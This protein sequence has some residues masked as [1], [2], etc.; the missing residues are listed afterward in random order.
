MEAR[1]SLPRLGLGIL[2]R[3]IE[4]LPDELRDAA[5]RQPPRGVRLAA[6]RRIAADMAVGDDPDIGSPGCPPVE[7]E[8]FK[9]YRRL[10]AAIAVYRKS[11]VPG[12][13]DIDRLHEPWDGGR[14][15]EQIDIALPAIAAARG[16]RT[17][18]PDHRSAG[19]HV[20]GR[21]VESPAGGIG[22]SDRVEHLLVDRLHEQATQ[23]RGI[24]E[25]RTEQGLQAVGTKDIARLC[26]GIDA[27][28]K[29]VVVG[30]EERGR[31]LQR[32]GGRSRDNVEGRALPAVRPRRQHA[33]AERSVRA[34][35]RQDENVA[36]D[37]RSMRALD[38]ARRRAGDV[39][40]DD[41]VARI[42]DQGAASAAR[43]HHRQP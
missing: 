42:D 12:V 27:F 4:Q 9:R 20:G 24:V 23:G 19:G 5:L 36:G 33:G 2:D 25:A 13:A 34:T 1:T 29:W 40:P 37:G 39:A 43:Q 17:H 7:H 38:E 8:G 28:Q 16:D 32:S 6:Q 30:A 35:A 26:R 11:V 22:G 14:S 31:R 18:V 21:H 41:G 15:D 3:C 10:D